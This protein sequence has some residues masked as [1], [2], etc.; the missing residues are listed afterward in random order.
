M[1]ISKR[2]LATGM[3]AAMISLSAGLAPS[4]ALAVQ[5]ECNPEVGQ[6]KGFGGMEGEM[7]DMGTP[8]QGFG[9]GSIETQLNLDKYSEGCSGQHGPRNLAPSNDPPT[10]NLTQRVGAVTAKVASAK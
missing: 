2:A 9:L 6:T 5:K 1:R 8:T 7:G 4:P 10:P 3:V